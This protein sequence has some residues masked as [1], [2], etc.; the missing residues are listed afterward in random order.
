MR[1]GAAGLGASGA[2]VLGVPFADRSL[3]CDE[4][5]TRRRGMRT[6][7]AAAAGCA[8]RAFHD[9]MARRAGHSTMLATV[10]GPVRKSY[11]GGLHLPPLRTRLPET[12]GCDQRH[13]NK[14]ASHGSRLCRAGP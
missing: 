14:T 3:R 2:Q 1:Q 12:L 6:A 7:G 4:N 8:L 5:R 11:D 9:W 10:T 13:H